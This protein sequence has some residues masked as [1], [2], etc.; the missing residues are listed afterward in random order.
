MEITPLTPL[1][2]RGEGEIPGFWEGAYHKEL[3]YYDFRKAKLL[4]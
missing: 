2:L 4:S 3:N 1:I